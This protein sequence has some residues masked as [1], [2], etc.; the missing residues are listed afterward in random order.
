VLFGK[1]LASPKEKKD[2]TIINYVIWKLISR[3]REDEKFYC[4]R[5][6]L[7]DLKTCLTERKS[8]NVAT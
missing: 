3:L 7:D 4:Q 2:K 1:K 8:P 5:S 6:K